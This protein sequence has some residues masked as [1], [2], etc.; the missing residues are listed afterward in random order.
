MDIGILYATIA[1]ICSVSIFT[2][3]LRV[4]NISDNSQLKKPF[5]SILTFF[6]LFSLID[7]TWGLF[8]SKEI[9]NSKVFL[10]IFSYAFHLGCALSA[11]LWIGF[12]CSFLQA[13]EQV[14]KAVDAVRWIVFSVQVV[15]LLTNIKTNYVF[16]IT[17]DLT[18]QTFRT[19]NVLFQLQFTYYLVCIGFLSI[20]LTQTKDIVKRGKFT[21]SIFFSA[22]PFLFGIG[23]MKYPDAP[24]YSLGFM[25]NCVAIYL[26]NITRE[27]EKAA[28]QHKN[29]ASRLNSIVTALASDYEA[30]YYINLETNSYQNIVAESL[31]NTEITPLL[32]NTNDF[33]KDINQNVANV[34]YP[35]DK[36]MLLSTL[37]KENIAKASENNKPISLVYRLLINGKIQ[38]FHLKCVFFEEKNNSKNLIIGISNIE[39]QMI[40]RQQTVEIIGALG[41][42]YESI[43]QVDTIND[44]FTTFRR[45]EYLNNTYKEDGLTYSEAFTNYINK[46]VHP[47]YRDEISRYA[48][49][50]YI[51]DI[52]KDKTS[53][54]YKYYDIHDGQDLYYEMRFI[55]PQKYEQDGKILVVFINRNEEILRQQR[56][57]FITSLSDDYDSV[58]YGNLTDNS[59]ENIRATSAFL[60]THELHHVNTFSSFNKKATE[61]IHPDD[62]EAFLAALSPDNISNK[63]NSQKSFY[64]SYRQVINNTV[65]YYRIKIM[66]TENW[67]KEKVF[68]IGTSN[69]D[70]LIRKQI[71]LTEENTRKTSV[72]NALAKS[73]ESICYVN[74]KTMEY[75]PYFGSTELSKWYKT[76]NYRTDFSQWVHAKVAREYQSTLL[77]AVSAESMKSYRK[78]VTGT[79][80]AVL[81]LQF[82]TEINGF[83]TYCEFS[84]SRI[85]DNH[86][87]VAI[88]NRD[89]IIRREQ[90]QRH[91]LAEAKEKAEVA[92][93]AKTTFLFN[94]SHDIRTPMNA[95]HG[96]IELAERNLDNR[97]KVA[98]YLSKAKTSGQHLLKLINDIL[99]MSRIESGKTTINPVP[100]DI[101][102][103]VDKLTAILSVSA[104]EKGVE[105]TTD[106]SSIQ[107]N[108]VYSDILHI[109]QIL[110]NIVS[111]AIKYTKPGGNVTLLIKQLENPEPD[112]G[113][114]CLTIKDTGVGMSRNFQNHIFEE[115]A[116]AKNTTESGIEGTGLG[117]AIVKRLVDMMKGDIK[118]ESEI[119]KGTIVQ[120][121]LTFK[122]ADKNMNIGKQT[123]NNAKTLSGKRLLLVEDN[124]LNREITREILLFEDLI[125]EEAE[126][127]AIA[128]KK[129]QMHEPDYY[130]FVLMDI[131]MPYMNG[132]QATSA[133][134]SLDNADYSKLPIIAMTANAF[135]ED[136]KDALESGMNYHLS[137]PIDV[138]S[139]IEC[140]K[141]HTHFSSDKN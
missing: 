32:K 130:D 11:F 24:F 76:D 63:L 29:E 91:T 107:N 116:R 34:I 56:E 54:S 121:Y 102:A 61:Y 136:I 88:Q 38:Y 99:D 2:V 135:E 22:I 25:I 134:R 30:V 72:L 75:I 117:M 16:Y 123:V 118:I 101:K 43:Y 129:V 19:R 127:G 60:K 82:R 81:S 8:F 94:M 36:E 126:D 69:V 140:L 74:L 77:S 21:A 96:F 47:D 113:S 44:T 132:Y 51:R 79:N 133:I 108:Y 139:L 78:K 125:I 17:P 41:E 92:S 37:S 59:I 39:E 109:N 86:I 84:I 7:G 110:I 138:P 80:N 4:R 31:Y 98:G 66:R 71:S 26:T 15:L 83:Q 124:E 35:D 103:E 115:F 12:I 89:S 73:Y 27:R 106:V 112:Q 67:E 70:E 46:D 20:L 18:Y 137:K 85:D 33:F 114:Y 95:V 57:M 119:G 14:K 58:Y 42:A 13:S 68:M 65:Q 23:Q 1:Y 52:L 105:F 64:V 10:T 45:S 49:I 28:I 100:T 48:N 9:L 3:F 5:L 93:R 53:F 104:K 55:R 141:N 128:V 120:V 111:N 97:E 131:Q 6:T 62:R 50:E 87:V 122:Y 40:E 90:E